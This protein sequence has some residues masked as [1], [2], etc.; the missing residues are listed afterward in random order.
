MKKKIY[1]IKNGYFTPLQ[2]DDIRFHFHTD[3]CCKKCGKKCP[4]EG[5]SPA[6]LYCTRE[7]IKSAGIPEENSPEYCLGIAKLLLM[8]EFRRAVDIYYVMADG[9]FG[10]YDGRHR[11]CVAQKLNTKSRG[12]MASVLVNLMLV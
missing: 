8:S 10:C 11:L 1:T 4:I 12:I 3:E 7:E 6:D 5:I 2:E 9:H